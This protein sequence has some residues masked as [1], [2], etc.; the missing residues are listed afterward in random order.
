MECEQCEQKNL[1]EGDLDVAVVVFVMV[2]ATEGSKAVLRF[3]DDWWQDQFKGIAGKMGD[4]SGVGPV[5]E[6]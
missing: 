3:F 6:S 4:A 2:A 1:G 5:M